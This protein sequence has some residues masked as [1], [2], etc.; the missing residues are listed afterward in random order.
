MLESIVRTIVTPVLFPA[1]IFTK[2]P[3]HWTRN[4]YYLLLRALNTF[5]GDKIPPK[6]YS[7]FPR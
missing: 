5:P 7:K 6:R 3:L 1:M 4:E 2:K